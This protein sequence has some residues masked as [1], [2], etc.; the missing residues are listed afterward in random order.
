MS[1]WNGLIV[2]LAAL[3]CL[4]QSVNI[5]IHYFRYETD[6]VISLGMVRNPTSSAMGAP[7]GLSFCTR[8]I[9]ALNYSYVEEYHPIL[10]QKLHPWIRCAII[11]Y[12]E[13]EY[14]ANAMAEVLK[15]MDLISLNRS[16]MDSSQLLVHVKVKDI[17][18]REANC[19][20]RP[21]MKLPSVCWTLFCEDEA[22][23]SSVVYWKRY[24]A[25]YG[26]EAI[27]AVKLR[28]DFIDEAY[29]DHVILVN[30]NQQ[31]YGSIRNALRMPPAPKWQNTTS[32]M[33]NIY[34]IRYKTY[35]V[36]R[37]GPPYKAQ[38]QRYPRN[39]AETQLQAIENKQND[40]LRTNYGHSLYGNVIALDTTF[41]NEHL[42]DPTRYNESMIAAL[43][44]KLQKVETSLECVESLFSP[45]LESNIR[46]VSNYTYVT[47]AAPNE[48]TIVVG[49]VA[50][51]PLGTYLIYLGSILGTWFGFSFMAVGNYASVWFAKYGTKIC[52]THKR[53]TTKLYNTSIKV[54]NRKCFSK[55]TKTDIWAPRQH[56][57]PNYYLKS[58][59]YGY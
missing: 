23:T 41:P 46:V 52:P 50:R 5:T 49:E 36:Q 35:I 1:P 26:L 8:L 16:I 59:V 14:E 20:L 40:I 58:K 19:R 44:E 39:G 31:P 37:L 51:M 10:Y 3:G 7:P 12:I 28:K 45:V 17:K 18:F 22:M 4:M 9:Y 56:R 38:C 54:Y 11:C 27:Y 43:T 6:A 24:M 48:P 53:R 2:F 34:K 47:I 33:S 21:I 29:I 13:K 42:M 15:D 30:M 32:V 25:G 55:I 57:I